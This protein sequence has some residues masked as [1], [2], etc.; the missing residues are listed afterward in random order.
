MSASNSTLFI[1]GQPSSNAQNS[2][3]KAKTSKDDKS[4]HTDISALNNKLD[5][6]IFQIAKCIDRL[7]AIDLTLQDEHSSLSSEQIEKLQEDKEK[8][9]QARDA[10]GTQ[11]SKLLRE[12]ENLTTIHG[13][14][15]KKRHQQKMRKLAA[16]KRCRWNEGIE[17]QGQEEVDQHIEG[18]INDAKEEEPEDVYETDETD[19]SVEFIICSPARFKYVLPAV[20]AKESETSTNAAGPEVPAKE[21]EAPTGAADTEVADNE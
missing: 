14:N 1:A 8:K 20:P 9:L 18:R 3:L 11:R 10:F 12:I 6:N 13:K 19:S 15:W 7:K 17:D 21:S 4:A 16:L 5:H 2:N